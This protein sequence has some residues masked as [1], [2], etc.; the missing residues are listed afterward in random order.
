M[1]VYGGECHDPVAC[2]WIHQRVWNGWDRAGGTVGLQ[3]FNRGR[4]YNRDVDKCD[5]GG[6]PGLQW[7]K[8]YGQ[9]LRDDPCGKPR[10]WHFPYL[11][12]GNLNG[13]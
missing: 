5:N 10:E 4:D 2:G 13:Y 8:D 3:G 7:G 12:G 1:G 11:C 9:S 6:V